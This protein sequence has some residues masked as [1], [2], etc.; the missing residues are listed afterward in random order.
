MGSC[1]NVGACSQTCVWCANL[2]GFKQSVRRYCSWFTWSAFV[3]E[4]VRNTNPVA[5]ME[6]KTD[7]CA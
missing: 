7:K 4:S 3:G 1:P 5:T 6:K 2:G